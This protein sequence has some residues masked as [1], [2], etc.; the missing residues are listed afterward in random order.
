MKR[1]RGIAT[2]WLE[3]M[4]SLRLLLDWA[5]AAPMRTACPV[6]MASDGFFL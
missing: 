6:P 5:E 1:E 4:E 2:S 3:Q